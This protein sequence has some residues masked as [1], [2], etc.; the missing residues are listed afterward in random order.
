LV[1]DAPGSSDL[2]NV[3]HCT[4]PE[5]M[6]ATC[7]ICTHEA[8]DDL[9]RALLGGASVRDVAGRSGVSKSA[10]DRHR[11]LCLAPRMANA[12]AR[13]EE[14]SEERLLSYAHG[15]LD[16]ASWGLVR[17]QRDE[18][19]FA[20]RAW[21]GEARKCVETLAKL[22]GIGRADVHVDVDARRVDA[23]FA[24]LSDD[25]LHALVHGGDVPAV[26]EGRARA[27]LPAPTSADAL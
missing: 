22:G 2:N 19:D 5:Y 9:N 25:E 27:A 21:L 12:I 13:H 1:A 16:H 14:L 3:P 4:Y 26:V 23:V 24:N 8:R 18:D 6:A 15:L 10:V 7:S 20:H 17:A 11:R